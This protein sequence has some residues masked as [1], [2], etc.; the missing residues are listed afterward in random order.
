MVNVAARSDSRFPFRADPAFLDIL[1]HGPGV[2]GDGDERMP[3]S[4]GRSSCRFV[5]IDTCLVALDS[6][7]GGVSRGSVTGAP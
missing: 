4:R 7:R 2:V 3:Q 5:A 1:E 6:P